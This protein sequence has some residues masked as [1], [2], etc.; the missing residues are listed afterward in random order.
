MAIMGHTQVGTSMRYV[1]LATA[2][3]GHLI[4]GRDV[5]RSEVSVSEEERLRS[6]FGWITGRSPNPDGGGV[7][8]GSTSRRKSVAGR[9]RLLWPE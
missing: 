9:P 8:V 2:N 7:I 5:W 3:M 4:R 6:L 1:K